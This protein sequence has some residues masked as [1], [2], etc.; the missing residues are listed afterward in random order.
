MHTLKKDL[1]L[2]SI[3]LM[4]CFFC[5][6]VSVLSKNSSPIYL[7]VLTN[8]MLFLTGIKILINGLRTMRGISFYTGLSIILVQVFCRYIDLIG[9]YIGGAA[10]FLIAGLIM[11]LAARFW[12]NHGSQQIQGAVA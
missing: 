6:T 8:L 3:G 1:L 12:K 9:N 5:L 2:V 11:I 10:L 7:Q 4:Y